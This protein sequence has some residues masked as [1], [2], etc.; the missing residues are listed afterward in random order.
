MGCLK[1][2]IKK[3][4]IIA[5]I[6][7]FFAFGGWALLKQKIND[8]KNPTRSEF[9]E[10]EKYYADFSSVPEDYQL[11]RSFNFFGYKKINAKYLPTGQKITIFDLKNE[12]KISAKDFE[13]KEID[14][15]ITIL[16]DK[17]KD[18]FI[19][20]EN[21]EIINRGT[22]RAENKAIP[23]IVFSADVKNIPFKKITGTLGAY[24]NKNKNSKVSTKIILSIV[25]KKAYNPNIV[26]NFAASLKF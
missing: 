5:L 6:A 11:T 9:V 20:F 19:T 8:Y 22:Y 3:I 23:Y 13:T 10:S 12:N 4:I 26:N 15:K 16:L 24:S 2:I 25:D 18:S 7:A 21:F 14:G 1:S 17:L